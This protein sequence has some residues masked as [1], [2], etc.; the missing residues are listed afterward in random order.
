MLR[1]AADEEEMA[2]VFRKHDVYSK[3]DIAA[4]VLDRAALLAEEPELRASLAGGLLV[5]SDSVLYPPAAARF[6][7]DRACAT[8][9][10]LLQ[11]Q[12]VV[13]AAHGRVYFSDG[14]QLQTTWIINA[15]G[16][17]AE[18]FSPD[19]PIRPRKGHL[20]ITDRYPGFARHQ[21]V[22]LGYLKS[23]HSVVADSVAFN[24]QDRATAHRFFPTIWGTRPP[25]LRRVFWRLFWIAPAGTCPDYKT[26]RLSAP[27]QDFAWQ[28]RIT[29]H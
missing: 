17:A 12:E 16:E 24:V 11:G 25:T 19:L 3:C 6:L 4:K 2:E 18:R 22:E 15:A 27:G 9:A 14:H 29:C 13:E 20:L 5:S 23:A 21:L 7:I 10:V 1:I 8:G 26:S 28:H